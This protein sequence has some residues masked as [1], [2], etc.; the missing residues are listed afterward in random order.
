M[1]HNSFDKLMRF[2]RNQSKTCTPLFA[3]K[4][5]EKKRKKRVDPVTVKRLKNESIPP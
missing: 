1:I 5:I 2:P 3:P 4:N